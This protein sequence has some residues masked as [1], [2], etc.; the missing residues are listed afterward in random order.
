MSI[1]K[2]ITAL[3]M[4]AGMSAGTAQ[5]SGTYIGINFGKSDVKEG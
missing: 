1:K 3:T 2:T 5:A 4:I